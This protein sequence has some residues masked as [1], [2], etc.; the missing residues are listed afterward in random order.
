[1][2][3]KLSNSQF[4]L[5]S[6][7][8][9]LML[10]VFQ[11]KNQK[12]HQKLD[13]RMIPKPS[14]SHSSLATAAFIVWTGGGSFLRSDPSPSVAMKELLCTSNVLNAV[15]HVV[16]HSFIPARSEDD[17][18][19]FEEEE[20]ARPLW[21][22]ATIRLQLDQK[23]FHKMIPWIDICEIEWWWWWWWWW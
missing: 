10:I 4:Y 19:E 18:E 13:Q 22:S 8:L 20:E 15:L 11:T 14:R 3:I 16:S 23:F 7:A 12:K 9:F 17:E 2:K 1:M 21:D 5:T 6:Q